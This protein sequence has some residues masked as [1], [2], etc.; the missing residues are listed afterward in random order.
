M[1]A[2]NCSSRNYTTCITNSAAWGIA[3]VMLV[4]AVSSAVK[5]KG[6]AEH[7]WRKIPCQY[8]RA[9]STAT[10]DASTCGRERFT[11]PFDNGKSVV[12]TAKSP[13]GLVILLLTTEI[14]GA[15][16]LMAKN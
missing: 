14:C 5:L 13:F 16:L 11:L 8:K 15:K 12:D 7:V 2:L 9:G 3:A 4:A 10:S 1:T 6:V